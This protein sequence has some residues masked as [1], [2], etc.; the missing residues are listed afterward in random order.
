MTPTYTITR[1]TDAVLRLDRATPPYDAIA[2]ALLNH[3]RR[4]APM[5]LAAKPVTTL[6]GCSRPTLGTL[7]GFSLTL[8]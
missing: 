5:W 2:F 1:V 7:E 6:R 3:D 8:S 4:G